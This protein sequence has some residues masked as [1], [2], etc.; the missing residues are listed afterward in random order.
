MKGRFLL[1]VAVILLCTGVLD[2]Q[3]GNKFDVTG[4]YSYLRFNPGLTSY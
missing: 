4:H 3:E 2:A 1:G